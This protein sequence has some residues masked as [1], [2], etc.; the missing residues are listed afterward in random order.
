[1]LVFAAYFAGVEA[2]AGIKWIVHL[3]TACVFV[4]GVVGLALSYLAV[5]PGEGEAE[6]SV[7]GSGG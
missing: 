3:W 7:D 1:M 5:P 4:A 2:T 6:P